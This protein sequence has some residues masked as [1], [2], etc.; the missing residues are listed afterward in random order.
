MP[1]TRRRLGMTRPCP[2]E[3]T[4]TL[5]HARARATNVCC[6][7]LGGDHPEK[8]LSI[9]EP[10]VVRHFRTDQAALGHDF[11]GAA[12][13]EL[14]QLL[15]PGGASCVDDTGAGWCYGEGDVA[16]AATGTCGAAVLFST[17]GDP[18]GAAHVFLQCIESAS[19]AA[20]P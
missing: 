16:R 11:T 9:A 10:D 15:P 13:C 7:G 4:G 19:A 2:Q 5:D 3:P 1:V 6:S 14:T 20:T 17:R 18:P 12:V 8:G